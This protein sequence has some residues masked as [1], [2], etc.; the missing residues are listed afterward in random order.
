MYIRS[1]T[2][3]DIWY[4]VRTVD[5]RDS[6]GEDRTSITSCECPAFVKNE[7]KC[8]HMFLASRICGYPVQHLPQTSTATS[9]I[10]LPSLDDHVTEEDTSSQKLGSL[11]RIKDELCTIS[12]LSASLAALDLATLSREALHTLET[13]ATR[14]R[15]D[16]SSIVH[17]KPLYATQLSS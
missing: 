1:F 8:K 16:F 4:L 6:F 9:A 5:Y 2:D 13:Q 7:L 12:N 11:A 14:L 15:R 17:D 3:P 10:V